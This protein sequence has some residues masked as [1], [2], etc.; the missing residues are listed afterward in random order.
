[1]VAAECLSR[2][3]WSGG[4]ASCIVSKLIL[5]KVLRDDEEVKA[6]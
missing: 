1:M 5:T 4:G 3:R 6:K 2:R